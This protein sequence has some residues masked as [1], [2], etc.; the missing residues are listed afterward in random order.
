MTEQLRLLDDSSARPWSS[1]AEPLVI[2]ESRRAR[3]LILQLI[4]PY[5]LEL[6]VP[7]GTRPG[8]VEAFLAESRAWLDRA[9]LE[10]QSRY[11]DAQQG[12]PD[13]V[14]LTAIGRQWQV[15]FLHDATV[16]PRRRVYDDRLEL[17]VPKADHRSACY[18]LR[19]WLMSEARRHLKPWLWREAEFMGLPPNRVQIR[20]QRTRWGSC[21]GKGT[22]SLNAGLL[23]LEP[24][25]TRY[26]LIHE[27]CHLRHLNHSGRYWKLV[28]RFEP[29]YRA[30]DRA[31]S[32][33][34]A[35]VP[36]W[37]LMG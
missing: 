9:R 1:E 22:I 27:L 3:R 28:E 33:S 17:T 26:L 36:A 8:E 5:T 25:V 10:M 35:R 20:T 31:L 7:R 15:E 2:R 37:V 21:S 11:P 29:N 6:V 4:P 16:R 19:Q 32:E 14:D 24:P 13:R 34:W 23:F 12:L 18:L 30:L